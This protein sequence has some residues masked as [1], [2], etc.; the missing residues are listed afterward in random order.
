[1][2][3]LALS[4][5][6]SAIG[7]PIGGMVGG[8]V[9]GLIDNVL[10][11]APVTPP[12]PITTSTYGKALPW[13]RGTDVRL[14]C[15][16]F[17]SSGWRKVPINK[18]AK[19]FLS[20]AKAL[21]AKSGTP[22]FE[23]DLAFSVM[24][25]PVDPDW[26]I[27]I[28]ANGSV[29][30]DSTL[31]A[32]RPTADIHGVV[33]WSDV[34]I[35][36]N[37]TAK[38]F[39]SLVVYP[40]NATQLPDPTLEAALG[41]GN[42]PAYRGTAY[43][44]INGLQGTPW[45]NSVP[46]LQ[47]MARPNAQGVKLNQVVND[48]IA[49]A[50]L[51]P[52]L[53]ST[54]SLSAPVQGYVV[55]SQA[56]GVTALQ[57]LALVYNFDLAE[58]GGGLRFTPRGRTPIAT[59]E[60]DQLAGH[61]FGGSRPSFQWPRE[62]ETNLPKLAAL[63]F[64]DPDRDCQE[65]TQ[66]AKRATGSAQSMLS[67]SVKVTMT[68]EQGRQVA[69]R[70]LWEAHIGRQT[71]TAATDDRTGFI[72]S[73]QT[74]AFEVPGGYDNVRVTSRTR[75]A[76][77]VIEFQG[78][79]DAPSI[80]ASA[81]PG[82]DAGSAPNVVGLGGPVNPPVF[83]EPPAGFPG[84]TGAQLMIALSG[85]DGTDANDA[86]D[87]CQVYVATDDVE[88]DYMLAGVQIGAAVMGVTSGSLGNYSGSNPDVNTVTGHV[89]AV[90]TSMSGGEPVAQ[91]FLDASLAQTVLLVGTEYMSGQHVNAV[92]G[93]VYDITD[94]W[95]G[96]YGSARQAHV[97][98][99]RFVQ[100]DGRVFRMNLAGVYVGVPLFFRFVSA[101]ETLAFATTY[102]YTPAGVVA[103][104]SGSTSSAIPASETIAAGALV[105]LWSDSG[106]LKM[107]NA[108]ATGTTKSA[109]GF[110]K[111][112]VASGSTGV[113]FTDGQTNDELSGLTPGATYYLAVGAGGHVTAT[114]PAVTGEGLQTVGKALSAT[115]LL[116]QGGA[117]TAVP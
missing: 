39:V 5:V 101:G 35:P 27:K 50:G 112:G 92:G 37:G 17:Y 64:I 34:G 116:Y 2:A 48:I 113:F 32:T 9:G 43:F 96:Q 6:G 29:L 107:R 30:F 31:A 22:S 103:S 59:I 52:A 33:T 105:N 98:G 18:G 114:P 100:V 109:D 49:S 82:A 16:M 10:F 14:G 3:S 73:A 19:A 69:D 53:A 54:S 28:F 46:I 115:S 91:S 41:I 44:V 40:G 20:P 60:A 89:L 72:E 23:C 1:M 93:G 58:V 55:D 80:Y 8:L 110:V 68:S 25:G 38:D 62:A 21:A 117:M 90:D 61:E 51:D 88:A 13:A 83:I 63:T 106:V 77:N 97:A 99:E 4:V 47:I 26:I 87:G 36:P 15:N 111:A 108:D 84:M 74:Y 102:T 81:A 104:T 94:L 95:R 79:R 45:G 75:G 57:P 71:L 76:N 66:S 86:W 7:G 11:P 67:S 12:P 42:V 24:A 56:D 70:M 78:K 85:G 65:N